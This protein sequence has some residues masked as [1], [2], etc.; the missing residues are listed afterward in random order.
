MST[1][2]AHIYMASLGATGTTLAR[3]R[4]MRGVVGAVNSRMN[5]I[6]APYTLMVQAFVLRALLFSLLRSSLP[7]RPVLWLTTVVHLVLYTTCICD[8]TRM[9]ASSMRT[10]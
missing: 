5:V 4:M 8:L 6:V 1:L 7:G 9:S 10:A 3:K 2:H